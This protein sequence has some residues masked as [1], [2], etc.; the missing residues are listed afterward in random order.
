MASRLILGACF[1]VRRPGMTVVGA[2]P[3]AISPAPFQAASGM[4][5]SA[6]AAMNWARAS[7]AKR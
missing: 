7:A 6:S 5:S 4:S 2:D 1:A 3:L